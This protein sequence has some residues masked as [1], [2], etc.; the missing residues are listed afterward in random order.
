M[1]I[2]LN[3]I[4]CVDK[5]GGMMF[6]KR[7][8]SRDAAVYEDIMKTVAGEVLYIKPYSEKLFLPISEKYGMPTVVP[9]PL[10]IAKDGE[11]CFIEDEDVSPLI[12]KIKKLL[13]YNWNRRYPYELSFDLT[14]PSSLF[15]LSDK[16]KFE[17][18]AH[19]EITRELFRKDHRSKAR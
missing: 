19:E 13:I 6:N 14:I 4:L 8:V 16:K 1:E 12:G 11:W 17:G 3:I 7:R 2:S 10:A 18:V 5:V 15:M 9:D